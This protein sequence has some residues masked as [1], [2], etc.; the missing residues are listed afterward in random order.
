[1]S[2]IKYI[3][4]R[5]GAKVPFKSDRIINAIYRAAVA[6][7]GR[8]KTT[9][10]KLAR[11]VVEYLEKSAPEKYIPNIEEI[12]DIVEKILIK[13]G[14]AQVAKAYILYRN[15][16]NHKRRERFKRSSHPSE[17]IPWA[18]IW[19]ILDWAVSK[20][21]HTIKSLNKRIK[22][23]EFPAIV[24]ESESFY[25]DNIN[26]AVELISE[27]GNNLKMVVIS[28]PSSS[29][30]TTTTIKLEQQLIKKG[31]NLNL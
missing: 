30:K 18:K 21:V 2:K 5:S 3:I 7:G 20:K 19:R 12:Q 27:K 15:E 14:H 24:N 11:E 13:N 31:L 17:N 22:K 26:T 4:K 28:G 16:R 6:L 8:D 1:M 10:G 9:A 29:G 25:L 23:G